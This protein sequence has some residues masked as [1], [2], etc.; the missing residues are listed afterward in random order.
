M[1]LTLTI[2]GWFYVATGLWPLF[3]M[4]SFEFVTGPKSDK[5]LVKTVALM[6]TCSG[7]IFILY[8]DTQ[9]AMIL[10][11]MNALA[12]SAIDIFYSLKKVISKIYLLDAVVELGF[13]AI[14]LF[15]SA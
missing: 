5:W 9:A 6:I 12:L 10:A 2:Q 4:K 8:N 1:S 3:H 13:V 7:V 11:I 14:Y 15:L